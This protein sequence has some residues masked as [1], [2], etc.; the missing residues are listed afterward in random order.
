MA[1]AKEKF[2]AGRLA[3]FQCP[4]GKSQAFMWCPDVQGLGVRATPNSARKRYIYESKVKGK[5]VRLTIGEVGVWSI[6]AAQA[7]A[8]RLQVL[9]D[10]GQDPRKVK[11]DAEATNVANAALLKQKEE[12]ET[13]TLKM[14]WD[15]YLADR[16]PHWS[17]RHYKDHID[18]MHAGGKTR[19]RDKRLTKAGVLASLA[20][21]RLVDLTS[22]LVKD[23]AKVEGQERSG[24]ARLGHRLLKA[25]LSWCMEHKTYKLIVTE[26]AAKNK[27]V[28]EKLG[29]PKKLTL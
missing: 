9:I 1:K 19:K 2:T 28:R 29:K 25:C 16:K 23:W 11:A 24:R 10:S 14:A 6:P 22:E 21:V 12:R 4:E 26:N 15:D 5:T 8:R 3:D 17:D 20:A 7:E 18:V 13:V 27:S